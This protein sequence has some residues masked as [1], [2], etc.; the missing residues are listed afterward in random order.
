MLYK[1]TGAENTNKWYWFLTAVLWADRISIRRRLGCSPYYMV[2]GT[3]PVLPLDM[4]ETTWL[5][6]IPI[7]IMTESDLIR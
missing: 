2:T 3:H 6:V 7:G 1:A 4:K 5:S